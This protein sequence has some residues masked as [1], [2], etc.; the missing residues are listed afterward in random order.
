[1]V[2]ERLDVKPNSLLWGERGPGLC[3]L[4]R[5]VVHKNTSQSANRKDISHMQS[6]SNDSD[7]AKYL[8]A[9]S[10]SKALLDLFVTA[11]LG[12][13]SERTSHLAERVAASAKGMSNGIAKMIICSYLR[14]NCL[15]DV[16]N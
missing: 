7:S 16:G 6:K 14:V 4:L 15:A 10:R 3:S 1:M 2:D 13:T 11:C 8:V 12:V 9:S 5:V